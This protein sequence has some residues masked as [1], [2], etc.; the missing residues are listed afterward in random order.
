MLERANPNVDTFVEVSAPDQARILRRA[1]DQFLTGT[2]SGGPLVSTTPGASAA[3]SPG[4]A[5]L[6]AAT[7]TQIVNQYTD[8]AIYNIPQEDGGPTLLHTV[9]WKLDAGF[10]G[11]V[12]SSVTVLLHWTS[13]LFTKRPNVKL[14]IY[15]ARRTAGVLQRQSGSSVVETLQVQTSFVPLLPQPAVVRYADIAGSLVG[16]FGDI[17][18]DLTNY[19]VQIDPLSG[20]PPGPGETGDLP[21]IYFSVTTDQQ[22]AGTQVEWRA[23][24]TS[25]RTIAGVGNVREVTWT[26]SNPDDPASVW[27]ENIGARTMTFRLKV[28]Q[29]VATSQLVYAITLPA[30]PDAAST[31][32]IVFERGLPAGTSATAELSTAGTGG[33]WTAVQN[34]DLMSVVQLAYH[35]R[36]TMTSSADGFRSPLVKQLGIEFR[37]RTDLSA[38]TIVE[39][40]S[41]DVGVPFLPPSIGEGRVT[42]VRTGRRDYRD[43]GSELATAGPDTQIEADIYLASRHPQVT[44]DDWFQRDRAVVSGR[45]PSATS[46]VLSLLSLTKTLKRKIPALIES[47]SS[48]HTVQATSPAPSST[49]FRVSPNLQ[50]ASP[51]GNEYDAKGYYLRVRKS[52]VPELPVGSTWTITGNTN[53]DKLDFTGSDELPAAFVAGDEVEVHSAVFQQ[54]TITWID[55]DPA[56][57]WLELLTLYLGV[58]IDRI[59]LADIGG[60]GGYPPTVVDRAPG[61]ATT[62]AK[63]KVTRKVTEQ[64][65]GDALIDQLSFIMGGVTVEIAG[66]IVFRQIYPLRDAAGRIT[67]TPDPVAAVFDARDYVGLDTPT[68]R[69]SRITVLSCDYGV[70]EAGAGGTPVSTT[71]AIDVDALA[72]YETQDVEGLGFAKVPDDIAR[73]IY[74]SSDAGRFLAEQV[75]AQVVFAGS[76]GLRVWSWS[77]V[78]A[79]PELTVGDS[80]VLVTDQYTDYDPGRRVAIRGNTAYPLVL[81]GTGEGGRR[82]R[83]FLQ[84]LAAVPSTNVQ[85][86]PGTL[87]PA[88]PGATAGPSLEVAIKHFA[89]TASIAHSEAGGTIA[90]YIDGVGPSAV[91][92]SPFSVSRPASGSRPIA[93]TIR[94][95]ATSGEYVSETVVVLPVGAD[96]DTVSTDLSMVPSN[97]LAGSEDFTLTASNPTGTPVMTVVLRGTTGST[98][99]G[100]NLFDGV[101]F[102]VSPLDPTV[103]ALRQAFSTTTQASIE[104]SAAVPGGVTTRIQ[105]TVQNQVKTSF[106]PSLE[107]T[108][109]LFA[110]TVSLAYTWTGT[111]ELSID[112][113]SYS[114]APASPLSVTRDSTEH[115]YAFR[116][117]LDGQVVPAVAI[118][119]PL[120]AG[121][122]APAFST[123]GFLPQTMA[124][125][126]GAGTTTIRASFAAS[127]P[128]SGAT[129][130]LL[131]EEEINAA[132][133]VSY[134]DAGVI[135]P[136]DFTSS[137]LL[138]ST[139]THPKRWRLTV[140]CKDSVGNVVAQATGLW[141]YNTF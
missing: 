49:Q 121:A 102:T 119:P 45:Q 24:T 128:P 43:P 111:L 8:N 27:V 38:E 129:Y 68:G 36:L 75:A 123:F 35:L 28:R 108:R 60:R 51:T 135:S 94:N 14:Q 92:A 127:N 141:T 107:L 72:A 71:N 50:G 93:Y 86:G 125:Y 56:A 116:T 64:V 118:I 26:R 100:S 120:G 29:F 132:S 97:L 21:E 39:H 84:G 53:V 19:R 79:H 25:S 90:L 30:L 61:D 105:R 95:T 31:G 137:F 66:Q 9:G 70:N 85:A 41:Q 23:D 113:G 65:T 82:F 16:G 88:P 101:P 4:G 62:Q 91:P 55:Q 99:G 103:R 131:I 20:P 63:L 77:A 5:L 17:T 58:S 10:G 3:A 40:M 110:A 104:G 67:V 130:D 11:C 12:L 48:V 138:K 37:N 1:P 112:G 98:L 42:I 46:E 69:E 126:T 109:T 32:R 78:D 140:Y 18:F 139:G 106:G 74:N 22:S 52:T 2:G 6:L 134:P 13:I 133:W 81:L 117:T 124:N 59:G 76:T 83:G 47:I 57:V 114:A 34:G 80:V 44:R 96:A 136:Y 115:T 54:D 33:P 89:T 73:W 15:R 122:A 7:D 87:P